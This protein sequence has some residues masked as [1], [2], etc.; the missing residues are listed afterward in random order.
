MRLYTTEVEIAAL[1]GDAGDGIL[2]IEAPSDLVVKIIKAVLYNLDNDTHEQLNFGFFPVTTKGSLVGAS[3]PAIQ[4]HD[5][6]DV[7]SSVTTFG[8]GN[9]GMTT[10]V[11]TWGD[12]FDEQ[13]F[14][15]VNGYEFNPPLVTIDGGPIISP[16]GLAG[17]RM[18]TIPSVAFQAKA[19]ITFGELG[20]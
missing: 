14:S 2:I 13:G 20:G 1:A 6:G 18:L 7:A 9:N 11:D 4:K 17:I 16:S 10:E 12:P 8:A 15:N 3:T 5:N 19:L